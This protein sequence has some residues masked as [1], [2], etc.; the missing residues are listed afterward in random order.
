MSNRQLKMVIRLAEEQRDQ[1]A[2]RLAE[3]QSRLQAAESQLQQLR[4]Y[5]QQYISSSDSEAL[6]GVS[7]QSL[8]DARRFI[9]ELDSV[10]TAQMRVVADR[11]HEVAQLSENWIE[12]MRYLQ[13]IE[14]LAELRAA[15]E[16][17]R[18]TKREQQLMDD[19]YA[20]QQRHRQR[21]PQR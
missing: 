10:I 21:H 16:Q 20:Q 12:T 5:Q 1:A 19:L 7:I 11:E 9:G 3:G 4:D 18:L 2:Q 6:A 14:R 17:L 13:G 15:D 8:M